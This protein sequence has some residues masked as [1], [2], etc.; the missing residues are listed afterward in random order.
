MR[1]PDVVIA[2]AG[3]IG[4]SCALELRAAGLSVTVVERGRAGR[5]AS[6]AAAG[7]LAAEDPAHP[8]A[9]RPMALHSFKLYRDYLEIIGER[10]GTHVPYETEWVLERAEGWRHHRT[11]LAALTGNGYRRHAEP[12]IDPRNL[13]AALLEAV[14]KSGITVQ[15][16]SP[17]RGAFQRDGGIDIKVRDTIVNCGTFLDCTGAWSPAPVHPAKGQMLRVSAP[18]LMAARGLGNIVVRTPDV[19]LVPRLDGSVVIGATVEDAGFNRAVHEE[20]IQHLRAE[21]AELLPALADA[22]E[23]ERWAGL[24]PDTPDHL[25]LMGR[26]GEHSFVAAGHF[27]NGILLAPATAQAMAELILGEPT[28]LDLA[29]FRPQ[30]FPEYSA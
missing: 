9:L 12:S 25:P 1:S 28:V 6:W 4:L 30:R 8:E 11:T 3:L 2:G 14:K 13:L 7:M 19:Y 22:P 17:V 16:D 18:G 5:E 15:E 29:P 23:V 27:R 20:D 21:A 24:R 26:T 10:S